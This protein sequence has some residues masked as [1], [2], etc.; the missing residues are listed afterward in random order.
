KLAFV[1]C[2]ARPPVCLV[3]LVGEVVPP[4]LTGRTRCRGV[5]RRELLLALVGREKNR[6]LQVRQGVN[7][8]TCGYRISRVGGGPHFPRAPSRALRPPGHEL[9]P[10]PTG[11]E[12][13]PA[14]VKRQP[15]ATLV[16]DRPCARRAYDRRQ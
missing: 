4:P 8:V 16:A 13:V 14:P 6:P 7:A 10:P 9:P 1:S 2:G 15:G 5:G 12:G 3:L 11:H